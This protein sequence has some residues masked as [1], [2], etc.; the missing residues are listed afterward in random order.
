MYDGWPAHT[1]SMGEAGTLPTLSKDSC[2]SIGLMVYRL[3]PSI[4]A[5][6]I[7]SWSLSRP[8]LSCNPSPFHRWCHNAGAQQLH[9]YRFTLHEQFE[10]DRGQAASGMTVHIGIQKRRR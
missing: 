10:W 6:T 3:R 2:S 1:A 7:S 4:C 8:P 9:Y 5:F